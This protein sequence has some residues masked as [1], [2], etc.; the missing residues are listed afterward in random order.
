MRKQ[1]PKRT[2]GDDQQKQAQ[3]ENQNVLAS[4]SGPVEGRRIRNHAVDP[5]RIGDVFDFAISE[6]FIPA[7]QFVLHLFVNAA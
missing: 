2:A 5:Y 3:Q 7:N 6:R 1:I 4:L